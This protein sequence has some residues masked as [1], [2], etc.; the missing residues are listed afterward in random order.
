MPQV[1]KLVARTSSYHPSIPQFAAGFTN[2][3]HDPSPTRRG[4]IPRGGRATV[5]ACRSLP[6]DFSLAE[7]AQ[8]YRPGIPQYVAGSWV[9]KRA[10]VQACRR[11]P[12]I[13]KLAELIVTYRPSMPQFAAVIE[14]SVE[15]L[16]GGGG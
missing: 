14:F 2:L 12:Q 13:F 9:L 4:A 11:I 10:I 1:L 7:S 16:M 3:T 8:T 6:Q 15:S 5:R